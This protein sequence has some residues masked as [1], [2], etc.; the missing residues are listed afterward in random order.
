MVT[1]GIRSLAIVVALC[2]A[3]GASV[4]GNVR[5]VRKTLE[6]SMLVTGTVTIRPDGTVQAHEV[7]P[8]L[9]L[10]EALRTFIDS[11]VSRWRFEPVKVDGEVVT[12]KVP[13]S[14]R[15]VASRAEDGKAL[16]VRIA[17]TQFGA[18][19][20]KANASDSVAIKSRA[21]LSYP[22][23]ALRMGGKGTVYLLV[24]VGRDGRVMDVEAEQVNL[25]VV[26]T[27]KQMD[28]LREDFARATVQGVKRWTFT[29]PTTG[30]E[31][32]ASHWVGRIAVNY[33]SH[34]ERPAEAGQW[35]TYVPGPRN[36]A[37]PWA[38]DKLR[39]AGSPDA[40]PEG[41]FQ[42]LGTGPRLLNGA[43]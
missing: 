32:N 15:L 21:P 19:E 36:T 6:S 11:V 40:V 13:M 27:T 3:V 14:L 28:F 17:S 12:A 5:E 41:G 25:R 10:S 22:V 26:G 35:E 9:E 23:N 20:D 24:R 4:A 31:A 42:T 8:K 30:P 29:P 1:R 16:A 34:G 38:G 18:A 7:D 39:T 43:G 2:A 33:V 37:I